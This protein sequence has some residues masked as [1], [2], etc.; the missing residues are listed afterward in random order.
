MFRPVFATVLL[1]VALAGHVPPQSDVLKSLR[2]AW[3][4]R[5]VNPI[6][7][8]W[9]ESNLLSVGFTGTV[10]Q[11]TDTNTLLVCISLDGREPSCMDYRNV[12]I[13]STAEGVHSVVA[14]WFIP[15]FGSCFD[16]DFT[17]QQILTEQVPGRDQ[18]SFVVVHPFQHSAVQWV[19]ALGA[20]LPHSV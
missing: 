14:C 15:G 18:V 1:C 8:A 9:V 16:Y 17:A 4:L 6:A 13:S 19:D 7:H 2:E 5:I 12:V 20:P 11:G 10:P 3:Q